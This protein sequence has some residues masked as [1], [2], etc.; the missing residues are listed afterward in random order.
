[1]PLYYNTAPPT[2]GSK[3]SI[4]RT[5][6][7]Y[8]LRDFLLHK[9][10]QNPIKYP[11]L[12][13]SING[14]PRGG[15]PFLDTMVGTGII[16]QHNPIEVDGIPRYN[17]AIVM[18]RYKNTD[19]TAP[20]FLDIENVPQVTIFPD[21]TAPSGINN[22]KQEDITLYGLLA[23]SNE[24]NYRKIS[25][26]KNQYVDAAKQID[27]ADFISLQPVQVAQQVGSYAD[28]YGALNLG[29]SG[30]VQ[31]AD[32]LGSVL[33]GG[34]GLAK[35]GLS[36]N[37]DIRASL[38]GRVLTATGLLNDTKLGI[39][40]GQQLAL[41]LANNAAFNSE[42]LILGTLNAQDNVLSLVKNGTLVG[43]RPD[44][45]ITKPTSGALDYTQRILG[46]NVPKSFVTDAGSIFQSENGSSGNI[47]RANAMLL[48]TGKGQVTALIANINANL[49][50]TSPNGYDNPD[51]SYFR[52][53]YAPGYKDNKGQ[54][55][56]NPKGYAF[57]KEDGTIFNFFRTGIKSPIPEINWNRSAMIETEGFKG[58][59]DVYGNGAST[60]KQPTFS[61][62]AFGVNSTD[63]NKPINA[64]SFTVPLAQLSDK[65]TMLGKTQQLFNS[66]GM[67]SIVS[68]KGDM[69][70][71]DGSQIQS[72]VAIGGGISKGSG[73][74]SAKKFNPDGT[75]KGTTDTADNTFCRAWT[76][77][78]RYDKVGNLIRH[79]G[80]NRKENDSQIIPEGGKVNGGW[81]QNTLGSV[82]GDKGFVQIG[83]Y[84]SDNLT[85]QTREVSF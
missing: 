21:S 71:K 63:T 75:V 9:N 68:S 73:V 46:F 11:Y 55:A 32:I 15:E 54:K 76:T 20:A 22:Y 17:N 52:S 28:E 10:I 37:F 2:P 53:G 65:K 23:K 79:R 82:L 72:A 83:P 12:S 48:N 31:A 43:F 16:I 30:A 6:T 47:E 67:K 33:N 29:G 42:Q 19:S 74:L 77:F 57:M 69:T 7:F 41:S 61:W 59:D 62:G 4:T 60:I 24:K 66:V 51:Y 84:K 14:A 5:A 27:M 80:L 40:A 56:I 78:N 81:R 8:G 3:N 1:M 70:I 58:L 38:A 35:G 49:I 18:N 36:T 50:G 44:Y 85:R 64:N 39:I 34:L 45:Q 13:T 25:T 26:L